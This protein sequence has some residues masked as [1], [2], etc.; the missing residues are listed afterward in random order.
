MFPLARKLYAS[1]VVLTVG[2][3]CRD[4]PPDDAPP[5]DAIAGAIVVSP[6]PDS[7]SW[8][9]DSVP[10]LVLGGQSTAAGEWY[11]VYTGAVTADSLI[12]VGNSSSGHIRFFTHDGTFRRSVGGEGGG[13]GKF[14]SVSWLAV[15]GDSILVFDRAQ[16]RFAV[17][18]DTGAFGR[19]FRV[20]HETSAV[21]PIGLLSD[22]TILVSSVVPRDIRR[23]P[24]LQQEATVLF[25]VALSGAVLDS[26]ASISGPQILTFN[27]GGSFRT[28]Q[29]PFGSSGLAVAVGSMIVTAHSHSPRLQVLDV[30]GTLVRTIELPVQPRALPRDE[31]DAFSTL[32]LSDAAP[33]RRVALRRIL[34]DVQW[35][36][37]APMIKE[38]RAGREG[39]LWV[40]TGSDDGGGFDKWF[41]VDVAGDSVASL[42]IPA[43]YRVLQP[44]RPM[45]ARIL[46]SNDV[47]SVAL[48]R[49]G[50]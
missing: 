30:S 33:N 17:L 44:G 46:D 29:V 9:L 32:M 47:E 43:R 49:V 8:T 42:W 24:P 14:D 36:A 34:S 16:R 28:S 40:N 11:R 12:V 35:P 50:Q 3:A 22:G 20:D 13:P 10:S 39:Y 26:V 38:L 1:V 41:I 6:P 48:I 7:A 15:H 37:S 19:H 31:V 18:D 5:D 2:V 27:A 4:A 45:L 25:R 23:G 21:W